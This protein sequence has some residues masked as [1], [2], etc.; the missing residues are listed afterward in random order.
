MGRVGDYEMFETVG[1]GAFSKVKRVR[2][3]PTNLYYVAK[4]IPKGIQPPKGDVFQEVI[5]LWKLK[6]QNIVQLVDILE[7]SNNYYIILEAVFGGDVCGLIMSHSGFLKEDTVAAL[8]FQLITGV[9]VCHQNGI[10]H[11]DLNPENLLLTEG[12]VLKISNFGLNRLLKQSNSFAKHNDYSHILPGTLA[13][14]APEVLEGTYDPFKADIWSLGCIL[15]VLL[16]GVS[17]FGHTTHVGEIEERIKTGCFGRMPESVSKSAK[18]LT[19]WLL[20]LNP[21]ERPSLDQVALHPF[22]EKHVPQKMYSRTKEKGSCG[23]HRQ[24]IS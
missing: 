2:H 3:I 13:Y 17:P 8:F 19:F 18:E 23:H 14:M 6:H 10:A 20:S 9:C 1:M 21:D 7:S 12:G 24:R 11:G 4:I 16:T 15:Y 22:L 5:I